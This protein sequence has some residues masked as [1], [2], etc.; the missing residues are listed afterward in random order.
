MATKITEYKQVDWHRFGEPLTPFLFIM[1]RGG[2]YFTFPSTINRIY[3][4]DASFDVRNSEGWS[5]AK[6]TL[7]D[8][9]FVNLEAFFL[10]ALILAQ[11]FSDTGDYWFC[12][13]R[14]GWTHYGD[15]FTD[16]S[17]GAN[18][19]ETQGIMSGTHFYI[20]K[21]LQYEID[22]AELRVSINLMDMGKK[23]FNPAGGY[24]KVGA[25]GNIG[26][27]NVT[28]QQTTTGGGGG[29]STTSNSTS[30]MDT[31][32][33][34][35][36]ADA[37]RWV[38]ENVANS[39]DMHNEAL[40]N[41]SQDS[42][43][44]NSNQGGSSGNSST[45]TVLN[46]VFKKEGGITHWDVIKAILDFHKILY[47]VRLTDPEPVPVD[48]TPKL[49]EIYVPQ[50]KSLEAAINDLCNLVPQRKTGSDPEIKE[51]FTIFPG[52]T[53]NLNESDS[54]NLDRPKIIFGYI[55]IAPVGPNSSVR[56]AEM[57][58][59]ARSYVYHPNSP[60]TS[61]GGKDDF[62]KPRNNLVR[63]ITYKYSGMSET[64]SAPKFYTIYRDPADGYKLK[65]RLTGDFT[66]TTGKALFGSDL[67]ETQSATLVE[68]LR[69]GMEL[70]LS[71]NSNY[72]DSNMLKVQTD[73]ILLNAL[74]LY[75][76]SVVEVTL[77]IIGDPWLDNTVFLADGSQVQEATPTYVDLYNCHFEVVVYR[78]D[79]QLSDLLTGVYTL[80]GKSCLCSHRITG[81]EYIT[82]LSLFKIPGEKLTV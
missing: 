34:S 29:G 48:E 1:F 32:F 20:V 5:S 80:T 54:A 31:A 51:R 44:G 66:D 22:D 45:S 19:E 75:M 63:S 79:G 4:N 7:S 77:E 53:L 13:C 27:V 73:K 38:H 9:D 46:N 17:V 33:S 2:E 28:Q 49:P 10:K 78:A 42:A 41:T 47:E 55:P 70:D 74:N 56:F 62:N 76:N 59:K 12:A 40:G 8:P 52:N 36:G 61:V 65:I 67:T 25:I 18:A 81:G 14:W 68:G 23:V 69:K 72:T 37:S 39:T 3:V 35:S 15:E 21:D 24:L 16:I 58:P 43:A 71:F 82:Q 11:S 30:D 50:E 6:I 64:L 60:E 57:F 26:N